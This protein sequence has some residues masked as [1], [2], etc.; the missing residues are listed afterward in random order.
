MG[1]SMLPFLRSISAARL[2]L[3]RKGSVAAA[4]AVIALS[5]TVLG[6]KLLLIAD[7]GSNVPY[8]DQWNGEGSNLYDPY[9]SGTLRLADLFST[10]NEH[11]IFFTRV[12]GLAQLELIGSWQ[13]LLQMAVNAVLHV[14]FIALLVMAM[15]GKAA[16]LSRFAALC[17]FCA[18]LFAIPFAYQN[19]LGGFQSQI[20]FLSIF[21]LL[22]MSLSGRHPAFH[23]KWIAG[24]ML[25]ALSWLGMAS[26][27][28]TLV[29]GAILAAGQQLGGTRRGR[30]EIAG[31]AVQLAAG[32]L[33][34]ALTPVIAEHAKYR[35]SGLGQFARAFFIGGA[36]PLPPLAI[37][38]I[39]LLQ[40]PAAL[41][42]LRIARE[43]E[44]LAGKEWTIVG[45]ALWVGLQIAAAAY[46]R[47]DGVLSPRYL[48]IWIIGLVAQFAALLALAPRPAARQAIVAFGLAWVLLVTGAYVTR[49]ALRLPAE[50]E[51]IRGEESA[52]SA[53]LKRL[54][55]TGD[56]ATL[57]GQRQEDLPYPDPVRLAAIA[58]SPQVRSIL[59][60][61]LF[62]S[63]PDRPLAYRHLAL[64]GG[65][66]L[67]PAGLPE[68]LRRLGAFFL[69]L[70]AALWI[71]ILLVAS[72]RG[73]ESAE[74][75]A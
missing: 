34:I 45:V 19:T 24:L 44:A 60:A 72:Y 64:R 35:A 62:E 22:S 50:L 33:L 58:A 75:A 30:R 51:E 31:I 39:V 63:A 23:P 5:L 36:W 53:N 73:P 38:G 37:L 71:G 28:L 15:R 13:P 69:G 65:L 14:G 16:S 42:W 26:G 12:I 2:S 21:S 29:A 55:A 68:W 52:R 10:H 57:Q 1:A 40:A 11:R 27:A 18:F 41:L 9:M 8:W 3:S 20:Y 59:P 43:R 61:P 56:P 66:R 46:A 54:L 7:I 17:L 74:A 32:A 4:A 47:S 48:D 49:A 25:G 70:G 67:E 6:A